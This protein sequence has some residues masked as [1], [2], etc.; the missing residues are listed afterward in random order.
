MSDEK[1]P[2]L[3]GGVFFFLLLQAVLPNGS[4]RDHKAGIKDEHKAPL[5][6]SDLIYVFTDSL[7]YGSEKDTSYYRE[8]NSEGSCNIPF[9]DIAVA[10][11]FDNT[12]KEKYSIALSRMTEF[13]NWHI[14]FEMKDW[15]VKA[16]LEIIEND[17]DILE[18]DRFY[19]LNSGQPVQVSDI[20]KMTVFELQPFL[21]GVLHFVLLERRELNYKG[22]PTLD[23]LGI[24]KER[25]ERKYNGNAGQTVLR[26]IEVSLYE[27]PIVM[28]SAQNETDDTT[29][30]ILQQ[31]DIESDDKI[32]ISNLSKPLQIFA[33]ALAA[34]KHQMAEQIRQNRK[35]EQQA[36][37]IDDT[38]S[39]S[40][41]DDASG[42][43][44]VIQQSIVNQYDDHAIN[45]G[46]VENLKL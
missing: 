5:V 38:E 29:D 10:T 3:C 14:N 34:Q 26:N 46:H 21:L 44:K 19:I 25:K 7:N 9:N 31:E 15:L 35:K 33:D 27:E 2:Y 36:E 17:T 4:A 1:T 11:A 6:M 37:V 18:T 39:S 22:K 43:A 45:I 32:I 30:S 20:K 16:L 13:V 42:S 41:A 28:A 24:K 8:C 40:A 23:T 12:I